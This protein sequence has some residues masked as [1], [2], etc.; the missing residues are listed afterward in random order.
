MKTIEKELKLYEEKFDDS[1]PT[2][3]MDGYTPAEISEIIKKC[4]E[5][6]KDV[7]EMGILS[8]DVIY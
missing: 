8:L 2:F 5:S 6:N 1:F 4:I 3:P 7:Y